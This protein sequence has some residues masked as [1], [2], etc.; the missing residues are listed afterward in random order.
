M[1]GGHYDAISYGITFQFP[2]H[3]KG[4]HLPSAREF[5]Q[6]LLLRKNMSARSMQV[7][8]RPVPP[9]G[10]PGG[11]QVHARHRDEYVAS[12]HSKDH[13][14]IECPAHHTL[15]GAGK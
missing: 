14:S 4:G 5:G 12:S 8:E 3:Y 15:D 6:N 11:E 2:R 10:E 9:F 7:N 13:Q 1:G